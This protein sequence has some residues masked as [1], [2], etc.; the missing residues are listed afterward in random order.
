M[1]K[2]NEFEHGIDTTTKARSDSLRFDGLSNEQ[3][4]HSSSD[5]L[6]TTEGGKK[7]FRDMIETFFNLQ[8]KRLQVL[9]SY[10]QGDNYSILAGSRRLDKEKADYRVRHKWGGYISSFATSYV[11][12]NPVTIGI[13]EGAEEEQL[14]VI[15]EIEWQND[16]NTK[17]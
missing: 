2:V 11:I 13:L 5:E 16:I 10:A 7:A 9:A 4:R 17:C 8:R 14:K 3:F 15:E 6:L 1:D 12:G